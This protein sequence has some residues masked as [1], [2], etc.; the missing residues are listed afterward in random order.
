M[1]V[2]DDAVMTADLHHYDHLDAFHRDTRRL[3]DELLGVVDD[4]LAG[5]RSGRRP[6]REE[7]RVLTA[8][9]F[10]LRDQG[11]P[12]GPPPTEARVDA[13]EDRLVRLNLRVA[14][15]VAS[16][17]ARRGL[18]VEDLSQVAALALL[19]AVRRFDT[20]RS[21]DFLTYAVPTIRGTVQRHFRDRGWVVR[22]PRPVQ[23]LQSRAVQ[24]R[25]SLA[26]HRGGEPS[27]E[28]IGR[29][30]GVSAADVREALQ[31]SGCF[32][33]LTLDLPAAENG[34][35]GDAWGGE[36]HDDFD[37]AEARAVL[38]PLVRALPTADRELLHLRFFEELSQQEIGRRVGMS[39]T[40]VSRHL[41][42]VLRG[43]HAELG[44]AA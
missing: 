33:P 14:E 21:D 4:A 20:H 22:P 39:Q 15:A 16:R 30:L 13:I 41:D 19:Q 2:Y 32:Q 31:A 10:E 1:T 38:A 9:L 40:Q 12:G 6:T 43:L 28:E 34:V 29:E 3:G 35:A 5:E 7:R 36:S 18:A 42:R 25:D 23:E 27:A 8:D 37:A 44:P 11:A 26:A 24:V 17:Y